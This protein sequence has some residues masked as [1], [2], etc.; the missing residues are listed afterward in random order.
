MN[1]NL[2]KTQCNELLQDTLNSKFA[3][4]YSEFSQKEF[5]EHLLS[6][7]RIDNVYDHLLKYV[8]NSLVRD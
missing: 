5:D 8:E 7:D 1:L 4:F 3:D 2:E 6:P